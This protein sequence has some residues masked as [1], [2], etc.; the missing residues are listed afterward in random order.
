MK[1]H[2]HFLSTFF[3]FCCVC[4][5]SCSGTFDPE[6]E[7]RIFYE[8][9]K[10]CDEVSGTVLL[11]ASVTGEGAPV[12][13]A[14]EYTIWTDDEMDALVFTGLAPDYTASFDT[15]AIRDGF[16]YYHAV[17]LDAKGNPID[18]KKRPYDARGIIPSF[19]GFMIRNNQ[20]DMTRPLIVM[21]APVEPDTGNLDEDLLD[22]QLEEH[23]TFSA[24]LMTHL[25]SLGF[26]P[27]F[28]FEDRT[29]VVIDPENL[30]TAAGDVPVHPIDLTGAPV[31]S[32]VLWSPGTLCFTSPFFETPVSNGIPDIW[33]YT[34]LDNIM[35]YHEFGPVDSKP[36]AVQFFNETVESLADTYNL[37]GDYFSMFEFETPVPYEE[38]E[39]ILGQKLETHIRNGATSVFIYDFYNKSTE[40]EMSSGSWPRFQEALDRANKNLGTSVRLGAIGTNSFQLMEYDDFNHAL[41]LGTQ[42]LVSSYG[43]P[44]DSR[45]GIIIAAHGSSTTNRL[46]DVSNIINNSVMNQSIN[47]Y[48]SERIGEIHPSS[49][50]F[51]IC[52]SEY[53]NDA[54]DGLR[55]VGEQVRD[56]Y[57]AGYDYI[58][59]FPMEWPWATR[60]VWLE[61][62]KNAVALI[63]LDK[64]E[65]EQ[66]FVRDSNNRSTVVIGTTVLVIGE[67]IFDQKDDN[68]DAYG[69]LKSAAAKLLEDR[70]KELTAAAQSVMH[71]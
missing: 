48:F 38:P 43:I 25:E 39:D 71:D 5:I 61:L 22:G 55:G 12:P 20:I 14:M 56:W 42:F 6:K 26:I 47:D 52:Y 30:S 23:L 3:L 66:V 7:I 58:F 27:S 32:F 9:P 21:G 29:T 2:K 60:D 59:I 10:G 62:R 24:S 16:V 49:P 31:D 28:C 33:E 13:A 35:L 64:E 67:T 17:P 1:A 45:I 11:K 57:E 50:D 40:F 41:F 15:T 8:N 63:P 51:L 34:A 18:I 19:K 68:P 44:S 46:Y 37:S 36:D 70:L 4:I 65:E 69:Y 54:D 53:S